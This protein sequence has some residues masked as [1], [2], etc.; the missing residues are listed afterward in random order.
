MGDR[1]MTPAALR[2]LLDQV[3]DGRL[4]PELAY[5]QVLATLWEQLF[6]DLGFARV[7]HYRTVR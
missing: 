7:D 5:Q 2:T 4:D 1:G 6:E 3:R